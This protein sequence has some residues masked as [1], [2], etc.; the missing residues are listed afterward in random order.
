MGEGRARQDCFSC[1]VLKIKEEMQLKVHWRCR[2][3]RSF[4]RGGTAVMEVGATLQR[5]VDAS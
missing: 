1:L 5:P 3:E 2:K 4:C